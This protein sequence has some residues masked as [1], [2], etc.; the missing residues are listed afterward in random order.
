MTGFHTAVLAAILAICSVAGGPAAAQTLIFEPGAEARFNWDSYRQ[1]AS[2]FD[3]EGQDLTI[4]GPWT[5]ADRALVENVLAY[6]TAATG[7]RVRYAGSDGFEQDI[8]IATQAGSAPNIAAIPQPGLLADLARRGYLSPLGDATADWMRHNYSAGQSWVDLGR[9]AGPDGQAD[10]YG[11]F[12]KAELKSLVWYVPEQFHE[13]GYQVPTTMEAL[14]AL[15]DRIVADGGTPWCIGLGS[16]AAT[17][18]PATDWV[19]DLLLRLHPAQVYDGWVSNAI[20]FDDARIVE[21]IAAYGRFVHTDGY[22][23]G[24]PGAVATTDFRDSPAGLF[25]LPP[26]CYLHRQASFIPSFFPKGTRLGADVDFFYFPPFAARDFDRPML[27]SG[28]L[29]AITDD[30][31]AARAFIAF[32]QTPIAHEVWMA[33]SGFLTPLTSANP[34]AYASDALR[35]QGRLLTQASSFRFDGSDLMPA[36]IGAGAFW[37][38]MVDF[39]GGQ[40]AAQVARRIQD[41]WAGID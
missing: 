31:P 32:L 4:T 9:A 2:D 22:V 25:S 20:P 29:W 17:G 7:A 16:G 12:Y 19:E 30:S 21:A 24:G 36:E 14:L 10:F 13:A 27:G 41:R 34:A 23:A 11:F 1:F 8:M 38:G 35:R 28:A 18:W 40:G 15:S 5:G 3:L 37:S 6:F 39:T 33:Q 26:R